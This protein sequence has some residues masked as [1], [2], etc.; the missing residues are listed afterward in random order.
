MR[1]ANGIHGPPPPKADPWPEDRVHSPFERDVIEAIG[2]LAPGE[3]ATYGEIAEEVGRPG[4]AQAVGNVV[5]RA[6]RLPW[7]RIVPADGRIY[8]THAPVQI[9]LLEAEG[10][11]IVDRRLV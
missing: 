8:C 10:H 5:R 3:L 9:P 7:W 6:R 1:D 2:S 4:A 11:R